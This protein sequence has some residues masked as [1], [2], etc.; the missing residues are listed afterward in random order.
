MELG[1]EWAGSDQPDVRAVIT[2]MREACLSGVQ[3]ISDRQPKQLGGIL[4]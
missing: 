3:L 1:G 4:G 2:R